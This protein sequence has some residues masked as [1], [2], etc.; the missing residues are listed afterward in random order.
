MHRTHTNTNL[1]LFG[2]EPHTEHDII[3]RVDLSRKILLFDVLLRRFLHVGQIFNYALGKSRKGWTTKRTN[4]PLSC[5]TKKKKRTMTT[6]KSM[7]SFW[8][9]KPNDDGGKPCTIIV[10]ITIQ[11]YWH[12]WLSVES[13]LPVQARNECRSSQSKHDS[14]HNWL[15]HHLKIGFRHETVDCK[16]TNFRTVLN[17]VLSYFWKKC[18]I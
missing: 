14:F 3:G 4:K 8:M 11:N 7:T 10:T 12:N 6:L 18:E 17:F 15:F 13:H 9:G 1:G 5:R 16:V 2:L